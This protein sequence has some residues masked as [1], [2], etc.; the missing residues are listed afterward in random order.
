MPNSSPESRPQTGEFSQENHG[1]TTKESRSSRRESLGRG[2]LK[3]LV[4]PDDNMTVSLP[5]RDSQ[6]TGRLSLDGKAY[7]RRVSFA[8]EVTLHKIDLIPQAV[9]PEQRH[10]RRR[11]TIAVVPHTPRDLSPPPTRSISP[12]FGA[13]EIMYD[14]SD[15]EME[16]AT[17]VFGSP[18]RPAPGFR[19]HEDHPDT[20]D[21]L[22]GTMDMSLTRHAAEDGET[23]DLTNPLGSIQVLQPTLSQQEPLPLPSQESLPMSLESESSQEVSQSQRPFGS[24]KSLFG[25][26]EESEEEVDMELTQPISQPLKSSEDPITQTPE[27]AP[28]DTSMSD[29]DGE[30]TMELTSIADVSMDKVTLKNTLLNRT[31]RAT[32]EN[33]SSIDMTVDQTKHVGSL[34][35]ETQ[36]PAPAEGDSLSDMTMDETRL[37]T[38]IRS[39]EDGE[40]TIDETRIHST[41]TNPHREKQITPLKASRSHTSES[42]SPMSSKRKKRPS[43]DAT[44]NDLRARINLLTPKKKLRTHSFDNADA[45]LPSAPF[46]PAESVLLSQVSTTNEIKSS[47]TPLRSSNSGVRASIVNSGKV[48]FGLS[49][50]VPL[51][52]SHKHSEDDEEVAEYQPVSL[53]QFLNDLS[54]EFFDDLNIND[55]FTVEFKSLPESHKVSDSEYA[56]AKNTKIPWLELYSFSCDELQKNMQQLKVLFDNLDTEFADENPR[57][58]REYYETKSIVQQKKMGDALIRMKQYSDYESEKAWSS[59]REK[60]LDELQIRLQKNLD[61]VQLDCQDM[62]NALTEAEELKRSAEEEAAAADNEYVS[63][64]KQKEIIDSQDYENVS[65]LQH[66]LL[67]ELTT[68]KTKQDD[69]QSLEQKL[70]NLDKENAELAA[71][72]QEVEEMKVQL[73]RQSQDPA[74][75]LNTELQALEALQQMIGMNIEVAKYKARITLKFDEVS[76]LSGCKP[77]SIEARLIYGPKKLDGSTVLD[78]LKSKCTMGSFIHGVEG[79]PL[80]RH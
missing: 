4:K 43:S 71:L 1:S 77:R 21:E 32:P 56:I 5:L 35:S 9:S 22:T 16:D 64:L 6:H 46:E 15:V 41:I 44:T 23:M 2:I 78:G 49:Q 51:A 25:D 27:A 34:I 50:K 38:T 14:S 12:E 24:I 7:R 48:D 40:I 19:I 53:A 33:D 18:E 20:D 59:W 31:L 67:M 17:N 80:V 68:L 75:R 58:V 72:E 60:L 3:P 55:D 52:P 57:L 8:P 76:I 36:A 28:Q 63:L 37:S 70:N 39:M 42:G 74:M 69:L 30:E 61:S 29:T 10:P 54:I 73:N 11:E 13:E 79:L 26:V 45:P 62:L 65:R 66:E 47:F